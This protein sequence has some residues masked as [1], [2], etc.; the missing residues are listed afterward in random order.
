M[1]RPVSSAAVKVT[2]PSGFTVPAERV[3]PAGMSEM[4]MDRTSPLSVRA[5][6]ISRS[7]AVSSFPEAG[8][9]A[10][11][12]VSAT[13]VTSTL[14]F[15]L[16]DAVSV[17]SVEVAVTVKSKSPLKSAGGVMVRPVSSAGVNVTVPS[18]FT[19]PADRV[20]PA[21][22]SEMVTDS[23]SSLSVRFD[24]ISS[25]IGLSSLPA[26]G[27]TAR[28]GV[29]AT[30][31]TST[32][33]F[34]LVDAVSAPSVEVAVTVRSK[35]PLKSA[36]G[37][38]VRPVS[39][40][41]VKVTVPSGFTVPAE[42]VA[43]AGI[44]EMVTDS[45]SSLSVRF[46]AISSAIGL[47]SS[48]D[49]G[50][51]ARVGVSATGITSIF[52]V[53]EICAVSVPSVEVAVTVRSK[54]PLK[55]VGGVMVRPVSS[56]GVKVTVPSGFT[57]PAERVAPA[58]MSEMVTDST[59]SLS[60]RFEAIS[61][62]IGVSSL[63]AAGVTARVGVSA[64]GVTSTLRFWLV[65]AVSVPSVEVAVTV[66]SKSPLKS[67][68]G[69]MVRPVSSAGVKVTDPSG[70]TVPA[71]RVAPAGISEMVIDSTSSLSVRFDAISSAIGLSSSP[72]AGVTARVG[73]SATGITST[74]SVSE[75]CAVSVPSVDIA[76][77]V[78]SKSPL[79]SAGGVI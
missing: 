76:M 61:S 12:G 68:G 13:G 72:D 65:D 54:S 2:D 33:R 74:F 67:A 79:K 34:W 78:R 69:V 5:E 21:G 70:F 16:V 31:A 63:P 77:T 14:R 30:G 32:F 18:G 58:G 29:S 56:A 3:A 24:A 23:T 8:V 51:T 42:R 25:A 46:D 35:S 37:V 38:M 7:M 45:T 66:R 10:R 40:A 53:S 44:S 17:P 19:V 62:A 9:T 55:S 43:P 36:G 64:T 41:G 71:D 57:V 22:I 73:V 48:P 52:S 4:V 20:A 49:A 39:S 28:V 59:S 26:A 60:L 75:I 11:V 27:V 1:V 6:L 15:W 50:V 47:S